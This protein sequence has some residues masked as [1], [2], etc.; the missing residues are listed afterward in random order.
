MNR[1]WWNYLSQIP[2]TYNID[3]LTRQLADIQKELAELSKPGQLPVKSVN[4]KL[5]VVILDAGD[6][7]A[8]PAGTAASAIADH[9][10]EPDPH[11]QYVEE[12]PEDGSLYA[13]KDGNWSPVQ[14]EQDYQRMTADGDFRITI[15]GSL[16]IAD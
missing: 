14:A 4:G 5:G 1:D 16:R 3:E 12:A 6:V 2:T 13:R 8:D 11:P 15:D 10:A 9:V 7:G